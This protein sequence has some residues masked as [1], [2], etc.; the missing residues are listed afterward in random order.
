M[1]ITRR[2]W[3]LA[4]VVLLAPGGFILGATLATNAYRKYRIGRPSEPPIV[5]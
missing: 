5:S 2:Q 4:A 1:H 3:G